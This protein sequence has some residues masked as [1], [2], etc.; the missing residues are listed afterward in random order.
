MILLRTYKGSGMVAMEMI[1]LA[2]NNRQ[3][4]AMMAG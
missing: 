4:V 1:R 3:T 2:M